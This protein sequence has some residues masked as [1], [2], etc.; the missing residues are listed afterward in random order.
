[1]TEQALQEESPE[2]GVSIGAVARATGIGI[3]TLRMWERRYGAPQS[4]RL[5]SG[6]RRYP[7]TE[8]ER[9]RLAA[10][11]MRQGFRAREVAAASAGALQ[12]MVL[13][14]RRRYRPGDVASPSDQREE[15]TEIDAWL[16]ATRQ[17]DDEGLTSQLRHDWSRLG[18]M[19]FVAERVAPFLERVGQDWREGELAISHEHFASER[20]GDFLASQWRRLNESGRTPPVLVASLPG[21]QHRLGLQ[22]CSLM[23]ALG[24]RKVLYVGPQTPP[25]EIVRMTTAHSPAAICLSVSITQDRAEVSRALGQLRLEIPSHVPIVVGGSGAPGGLDGVLCMTNLSEFHD[26]IQRLE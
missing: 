2:Q 19:R 10:E 17:F 6:H 22:M 26:W 24:E 1:M 8:I 16:E 3:E 9:L 25:P 12:A 11:A 21:D 18:P 23:A 4:I 15:P 20:V 7:E 5:P 13:A 14:G